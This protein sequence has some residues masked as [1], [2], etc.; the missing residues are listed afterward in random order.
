MPISFQATE[1]EGLQIITPHIFSDNRGDYIKIYEKNV[2]SDHGIACTFSESS[3]I[4]STKGVLRGLHYQTIDSQAK[5]VHVIRG[6]VYDVAV[7]LRRHSKTFGQWKSF[8]LTGEKDEAVFIPEGFAHGFLV[9][10]KDTVFTYQCSGV[11][12]PEYCGGLMWDDPTLAI[13]WP[14]SGID[15]VVLSEKDKHNLSLEEYKKRCM[16]AD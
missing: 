6:S 15:E 8:L 11:Y 14:L 1:I 3:E 13:D 9:L 5:L 4:V 12:R 10:E 7:D 2:Y 16:G